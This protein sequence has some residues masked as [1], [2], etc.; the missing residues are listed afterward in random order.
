M[1][2]VDHAALAKRTAAALSRND[3]DELAALNA[4]DL[5]N[6]WPQSGERVVGFANWWATISNYPS[7]I[8]SGDD[9]ATVTAEPHAAVKLVAPT[10]TFVSV[11][12]AGTS[13]TMTMKTRYPDGTEW[14]LVLLYRLRDG[15]FSHVTAFFA[16]VYPAPEWRA[17]W[18][19][20]IPA[21][22]AH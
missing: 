5:I 10:Y 4:P 20:P 14:W 12:G 21:A 18:V 16:P 2:I 9:L 8:G 13:G 1:V 3:H 15:R 22:G 7:G 17:Q 19:E 6:E 11:E